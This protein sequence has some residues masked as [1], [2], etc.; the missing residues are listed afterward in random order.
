MDLI[1]S[2]MSLILI[3][4]ACL[5]LWVIGL[6]FLWK[7]ASGFRFNRRIVFLAIGLVGLGLLLAKPLNVIEINSANVQINTSNYNRDTTLN[8]E[9]GIIHSFDNV[10]EFLNSNVASRTL[11]VHIKGLGL[12]REDLDLI[13]EYRLHYQPAVL[14]SGI[15]SIHVPII[16]ES[17]NWT[18]D[19]VIQGD[20]VSAIYLKNPDQTESWASV[21]GSTFS[22]SAT[23]TVAGSYLIPVITLLSSGDTLQDVLPI[24]VEKETN[25]QLLVLASF[26]SFEINYLKNYWTALGNGFALRTKI[27]KNKF[28]ST[29]INTRKINLDILSRKTLL[30]F[31]FIIAD[32]K[33]WNDLSTREQSNI[34]RAVYDKGLTLIIKPVIDSKT[35]SNLSLPSWR[36][37]KDIQWET[38]LE[39][40]TLS[41]Y[42]LQSNWRSVSQQGHVLA[43]Y[44]SSGLGHIALLG[45]DDTYKLILS[46]CEADYQNLWADIF[47][48]LLRE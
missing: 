9:S 38:S 46:N 18:L 19:G 45:I 31:D 6:I 28:N 24:D 40:V 44:M 4:V 36:D 8:I 27:S 13:K 32:S 17:K 39:E 5:L 1:E 48:K 11:D 7:G 23:G 14:H 20:N 25:W 33:T 26:P 47:S 34:K 35:T 3:F 41:Q 15:S 21:S 37:A 43:K 30:E 12:S 10:H 22:V 42:N 16:T 29:F 2:H